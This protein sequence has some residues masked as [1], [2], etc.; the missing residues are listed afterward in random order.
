[1]EFGREGSEIEMGLSVSAPAGII[2]GIHQVGRA[3][4]FTCLRFLESVQ[5][6]SI[7][8]ETLLNADGHPQYMTIPALRHLCILVWEKVRTTSIDEMS[9]GD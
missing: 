4:E 2:R 5:L 6:D 8:G 7:T 3:V 1:M 9:S